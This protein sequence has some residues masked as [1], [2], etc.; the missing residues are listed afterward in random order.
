MKLCLLFKNLFDYDIVL[1]PPINL[2][3]NIDTIYLTDNKITQNCALSK[4]WK[5]SYITEKFINNTNSIEKRN[6]IGYIN[7]YPE[8]IIPELKNYD[9]VFICDSNIIRLDTNYGEFINSVSNK[10]ALYITSGYYNGTDN[11]I[12]KELERSLSNRRWNYDF[13]NI[14]DATYKYLEIFSNM[15]IDYRNIPVVSAKYIGWNINH[16]NKN[17]IADYVFN[18]HC[19]HLQGNIIFSTCVVLY[20]EDTLHY[21]QFL[22]DGQVSEHTKIF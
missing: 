21:T 19:K 10:H 20:P 13:K 4:G 11:N 17:I 3:E 2:C 7:C 1:P 15:N 16:E 18:E 14:K 8:K 5:Y 22:N 6:A 12:L 9:Y